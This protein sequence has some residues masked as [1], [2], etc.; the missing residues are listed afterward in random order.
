MM[1]LQLNSYLLLNSINRYSSPK[2]FYWLFLFDCWSE[3]FWTNSH[4]RIY[5]KCRPGQRKKCRP[6][7]ANGDK[8]KV[9]I[10]S[11]HF[12]FWILEKFRHLALLTHQPP[13]RSQ[14]DGALFGLKHD[15]SERRKT[16]PLVETRDPW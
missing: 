11:W 2:E 4:G 14:Y 1:Q 16:P 3:L 15:K 7:T 10:K 9:F 8:I 13:N 12:T 5:R 6:I